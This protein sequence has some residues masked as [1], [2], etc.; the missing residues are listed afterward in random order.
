MLTR[1]DMLTLGM[2]VDVNKAYELLRM[3]KDAGQSHINVE[4]ILDEAAPKIGGVEEYIKKL[5]HSSQIRK[6]CNF[7]ELATWL[8]VSRQTVYNWKKFGYLVYD[9]TAID[10]A[11]TVE[12][13]KSIPWLSGK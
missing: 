4:T 7:S 10:L 8:N 3:F 13:W 2:Q 9:K 12:L 6:T 11:A 5:E 1:S